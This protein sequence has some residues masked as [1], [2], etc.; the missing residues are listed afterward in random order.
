MDFCCLGADLCH[1]SAKCIDRDK[2]TTIARHQKTYECR[3]PDSG[4]TVDDGVSCYQN[5]A[6]HPAQA[7]I[8]D[9]F[10]SQDMS[11]EKCMTA[12]TC[13]MDLTGKL[14]R[15]LFGI[16]FGSQ[17]CKL[18]Y[19]LNRCNQWRFGSNCWIDIRWIIFGIV[20]TLIF[21]A[22]FICYVLERLG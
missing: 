11:C 14:C 21:L 20:L 3:C 19:P 10:T 12:G 2:M 5:L 6:H 1:P 4:I 9:S 17:L 13:S 18:Y 16:K 8:M 15:Y 22:T 7:Y